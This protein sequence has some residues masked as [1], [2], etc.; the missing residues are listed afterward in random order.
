MARLGL[1]FSNL[2]FFQLS[3]AKL[4]EPLLEVIEP[5]RAHQVGLGPV[6]LGAVGG[7]VQPRQDLVQ[8][9]LYR[10]AQVVF[11]GGYTDILFAC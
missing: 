7:G 2:F 8:L 4:L 10:A 11:R 3:H 9:G 5:V 6:R 1:K